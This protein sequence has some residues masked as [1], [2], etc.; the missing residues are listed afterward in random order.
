MALPV[1]LSS[2][3]ENTLN[4]YLALSPHSPVRLAAMSGRVIKLHITGL[5][6]LL[7]FLPNAQNIMVLGEYA[8]EADAIIQGSAM[9]F[10]R[11]NFASNSGKAM[12][13]ND[14]R[15]LGDTQLGEKFSQLLREADIDWEEWLSRAVGD[16]LAHQAGQLG[17]SSLGW[18]QD[19][20]T[21]MRMNMSE[22]LQEESRIVPAQAEVSYYMDEVDRLRLDTDRLEARITR[23]HNLQKS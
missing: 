11:L 4:R 20:N 2:L 18:L 21:A 1:S 6:I 19:S 3:L 12:L 16:I 14:V 10:M 15:I 7:Y 22:Y 5:D 23:M 9:A 13:E 8:D 17:R